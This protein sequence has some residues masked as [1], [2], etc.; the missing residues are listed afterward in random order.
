M[1]YS[2]LA[3]FVVLIHF[4]FIVYAIFGAA[5]GWVWRHS[6]FIHLPVFLWAGLVMLTGWICPLTPLEN[7]LREL[8]GRPPYHTGFI[9][10]YILGIIY[11]AGL[12]RGTQIVLGI[13]VIGWNATLYLLL[14][15]YPQAPREK[16]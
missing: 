8:A 14:W 16:S 9:D 15:K 6:I 13:A 2:L 7:H 3:D 12:T 4:A 10:H 5:L 1:P 11:P